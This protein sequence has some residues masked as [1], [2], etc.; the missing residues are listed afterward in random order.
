MTRAH[1]AT[2]GFQHR[3]FAAASDLAALR[4]VSNCMI[5]HD[6]DCAI[7]QRQACNCVP[8]ISITNDGSVLVIDA[9]GVVSKTGKE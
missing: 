8:E 7:F 5:E 4:G 3:L 9:Q 6:N 1:N 2:R